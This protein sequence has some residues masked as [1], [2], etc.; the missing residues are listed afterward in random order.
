MVF[1]A[2]YFGG[3]KIGLGP[4]NDQAPVF[5]VNESPLGGAVA[6]GGSIAMTGS[7]VSS[8]FAVAGGN[9]AW[10]QRGGGLYAG[11]LRWPD[12]GR[13]RIPLGRVP[14]AA[15]GPAGC[16]LVTDGD[17]FNVVFRVPLRAAAAG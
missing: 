1:T 14:G 16:R 9:G 5:Q 3:H 8:N 15:A 4:T 2:L 11:T 17:L 10:E 13:A 6:A 12:A 7:T